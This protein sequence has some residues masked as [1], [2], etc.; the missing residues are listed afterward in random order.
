MLISINLSST[1]RLEYWQDYVIFM[2]NE[3][4]NSFSIQF[5]EQS[6]LI[7]IKQLMI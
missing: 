3:S 1:P 2:K 5:M 6:E 4:M 7:E